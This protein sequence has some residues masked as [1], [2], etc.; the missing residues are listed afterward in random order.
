M[1]W[2][3][4]TT[5]KEAQESKVYYTHGSYKQEAS[6]TPCRATWEST[7]MV[8]RQKKG[9][10]GR[11]RPEPSVGFPQERKGKAGETVWDWLV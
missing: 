6:G 3:G 10:R 7:C 11:W 4:A 5:R 2:S 9:A 8:R 1:R